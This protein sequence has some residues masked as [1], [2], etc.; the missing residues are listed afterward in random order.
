MGNVR[1]RPF[2]DREWFPLHLHMQPHPYPGKLVVFEGIDGSGKTTLLSALAHYLK[3]A[4]QNVTVTKTPTD[5]VRNM[6]AWRAWSDGSYEIPREDIH[7][8][9]LSI[10]ALGDRFV[11]QKSLVEP[12]LRQG[13]WVLCDRYALAS[14]VYE[15]GIVHEHLMQ[16]L[17]Q[18]DLAIV[19]NVDP[20]IALQRIRKRDYE[21]E[22]PDDSEELVMTQKR[23]LQLAAV[24]NCLVLETAT[25]SQEETFSQLK[26]AVESLLHTMKGNQ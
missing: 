16:L 7:G 15:C 4:S 20:T 26:P 9:G 5:D 21:N 2:D 17:I 18:P 23:Y 1:S 14:V 8:Y 19:V 12:A 10:I 11:H 22:H 6:R 25:L 24:N 3:D 13:H